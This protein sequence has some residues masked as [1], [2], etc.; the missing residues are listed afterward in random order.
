MADLKAQKV[1]EL[2]D[3]GTMYLYTIGIVP[4]GCVSGY[5]DN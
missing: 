1:N 4:M 2:V 5:I 3:L